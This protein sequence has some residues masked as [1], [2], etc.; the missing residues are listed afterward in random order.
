M[1]EAKSI[2]AIQTGN[3]NELENISNEQGQHEQNDIL[4]IVIHIPV[5]R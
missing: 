1:K 4:V 3:I 5:L 2:Q